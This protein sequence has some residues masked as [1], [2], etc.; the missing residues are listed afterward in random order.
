MAPAAKINRA[1]RAYS[2]RAIS[3]RFRWEHHRNRGGRSLR[4][5]NRVHSCES[6]RYLR[7]GCFIATSA[8][9]TL[10]YILAEESHPRK[11]QSPRFDHRVTIPDRVR[12][13]LFPRSSTRSYRYFAEQTDE[14][15]SS[16]PDLLTTIGK[17]IC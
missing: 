14:R 12:D 11:P 16:T 9:L 13:T 3:S 2:F 15:G 4:L 7:L 8:T 5:R 17:M 6:T 1:V 10:N